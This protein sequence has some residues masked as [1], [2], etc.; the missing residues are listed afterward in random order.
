MTYFCDAWPGDRAF[1]L[2]PR[3]IKLFGGYDGATGI[4]NPAATPN[5]LSGNIGNRFTRDDNSYHVMV[6]A[7]LGSDSTI[8]DGFT[9]TGGAAEGSGPFSYNGLSRFISTVSAAFS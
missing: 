6:I 9:I 5:V 3:S 1:V 2:P 4:R 7:G 8:I